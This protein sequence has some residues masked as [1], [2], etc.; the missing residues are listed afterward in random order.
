MLPNL[1][2]V[3]LCIKINIV[4]RIRHVALI[5]LP[6]LILILV[7]DHLTYGQRH[8]ENEELTVVED[9][10]PKHCTN[11]DIEAVGEQRSHPRLKKHVARR[12]ILQ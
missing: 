2:Q 1:L 6:Q 4:E 7:L 9:L 10:V 3:H 12:L 11:L 5:K 8:S